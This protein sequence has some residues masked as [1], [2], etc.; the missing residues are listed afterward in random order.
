MAPRLLA[1]RIA[2]LVAL[3]APVAFAQPPPEPLE[4]EEEPAEPAPPEPPPAADPAEEPEAPAELLPPGADVSD[5]DEEAPPAPVPPARN[6]LGG[7]LMLAGSAGWALP[8]GKLE[9]GVRESSQL[10]TATSVGL[11][12]GWGLG[13]NVV[14]GVWG[15]LGLHGAGDACP[16]CSARSVAAGPF[17]RY[18][19]VQGMRFDPWMGVGL[20]FRTTRIDTGTTTLTYSGIEWARI[21]LGGDWYALDSVGLGPFLD[22]ELAVYNARSEGEI[23]EKTASWTMSTGARVTF[24]APGRR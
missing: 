8:L 18:H 12:A 10:G 16:G 2:C 4:L 1:H 24:D 6:L 15:K 5:D 9:A 23:G 17:V 20:G 21:A 7:H 11:D 19:L 22:F 13:R 3:A 14:A